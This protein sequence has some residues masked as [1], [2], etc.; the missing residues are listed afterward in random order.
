LTLL[1][2]NATA[3]YPCRTRGEAPL[4]N[5]WLRIDGG[6]IAGLGAEPCPEGIA[7]GARVIDGTG[8]LVIPGLINLHHHFFQSLTR[9]VPAGLSAYSVDWL[10]TMYPCGRNWTARRST[11]RRASRRR[12]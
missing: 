6:A 8:R 7:D 12:S 10:R 9:A 3:L 4:V 11:R 2:R 1:I 5:A